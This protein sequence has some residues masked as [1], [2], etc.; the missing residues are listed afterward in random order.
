[1]RIM[2]AMNESENEDEWL[3]NLPGFGVNIEVHDSKKRGR[4]Y[5]YELMDTSGFAEGK[6]IPQN[7]KSRS[8][9][10]GTMY[11]AEGVQSFFKEKE[12]Q[13]ELEHKLHG[14]RN[15]DNEH[16]TGNE[17]EHVVAGTGS[18]VNRP[19]G[20]HDRLFVGHPYQ[21]LLLRLAHQVANHVPFGQI[22][23]EVSLDTPAVHMGRHRVPNTAGLQFGKAHLQLAG[24]LFE[25]IF[26]D[27]L[28]DY[29]VVALF[30][31]T[32]GERVGLQRTLGLTAQRPI[33]LPSPYPK[34]P[35]SFP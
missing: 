9:K 14:N 21:T 4:Y 5:T 23:I 19:F 11:D 3:K 22:E 8:Y 32:G 30:H 1:M 31:L 18:S 27:Q 6:K 10:M 20:R 28:V 2:A 17:D 26:H 12:Q 15:S 24:S 16:V 33:Q 7:L 29:A 25:H 13:K 34:V 35:A